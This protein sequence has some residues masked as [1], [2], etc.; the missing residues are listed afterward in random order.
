MVMHLHYQAVLWNS[1]GVRNSFKIPRGGR[2]CAEVPATVNHHG[3]Q[4]VH[5]V[6][7]GGIPRG[8]EEPQLQGEHHP[9]AQLGV[10]VQLVHVLEPLQVQS[11]DH[12]QLLHPHSGAQKYVKWQVRTRK[13]LQK[14]ICS[15]MASLWGSVVKGVQNIGRIKNPFFFSLLVRTGNKYLFQIINSTTGIWMQD[16]CRTTSIF[17]PSVGRK[18]WNK[19][20]LLLWL[21]QVWGE[22]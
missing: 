7:V 16:N 3:H 22:T 10:A 11:Q 4:V 6:G 12:G 17:H 14:K 15:R 18:S 9:V 8:V 20:V 5:P 21:W 13:S 1:T 2:E 19:S